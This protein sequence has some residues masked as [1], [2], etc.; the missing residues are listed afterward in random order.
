MHQPDKG[1]SI[2][3][4]VNYV[5]VSC[6]NHIRTLEDLKEQFDRNFT[7]TFL[8][9]FETKKHINFLDFMIKIKVSASMIADFHK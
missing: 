9:E 3:A 6:M 1:K 5:V 4:I 8:C 7:L 2:Q